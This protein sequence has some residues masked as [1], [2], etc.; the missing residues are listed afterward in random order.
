[1]AVLVYINGTIVLRVE[2]DLETMKN[3]YELALE[4]NRALKVTTDD[5]KTRVV[6]PA[7]ISY[8]EEEDDPQESGQAADRSGVPA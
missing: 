4:K 1:M 7:Q 5:G 8:F 6:N 3:A 2:T